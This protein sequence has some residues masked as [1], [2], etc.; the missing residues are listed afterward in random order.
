MPVPV[1]TISLPNIITPN[2]D[3]KNDAFIVGFG[4]DKS[5]RDFGFPVSLKI[6]NRWGILVFESSD[7]ENNWSGSGHPE[8]VYYYDVTIEQHTECKSW[9]QIMR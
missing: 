7:Y 8:G 3:D 2:Q 9:V 6:Y 5:P 1:F 4:K